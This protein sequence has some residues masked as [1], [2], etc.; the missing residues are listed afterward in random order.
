[1]TLTRIAGRLGTRAVR[2]PASA[3]DHMLTELLH[4]FD[5]ARSY[6]LYSTAIGR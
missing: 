2:P 1:M 6:D 4:R 3:A 5:D